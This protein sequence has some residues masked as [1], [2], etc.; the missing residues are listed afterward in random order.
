MILLVD[1][2]TSFFLKFLVLFQ[3]LNLVKFHWISM[4]S[5]CINN[6]GDSLLH[7]CFKYPNDS[8]I[9]N[10]SLF[11]NNWINPRLTAT[12]TTFFILILPF[13]LFHDVPLSLIKLQL[14]KYSKIKIESLNFLHRIVY[15]L[16]LNVVL[17]TIFRQR[18]PCSCGVNGEY[19]HIGSAYGC[20][21][22]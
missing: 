5:T 20:L 21:H 2:Y 15:S 18:R 4:I 22:L 8:F 1:F 16:V 6:N 13:I 14:E 11:V 3:K 7:M 9:Y 19:H 17:Y 12:L 10:F